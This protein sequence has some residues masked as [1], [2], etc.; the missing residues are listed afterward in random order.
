MERLLHPKRPLRQGVSASNGSGD[1]N[2]LQYF[3]IGS[4]LGTGLLHVVERAHFII[5]KQSD[6][7]RD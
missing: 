5:R 6:A 4:S 7:K 3:L 1:G 2:G